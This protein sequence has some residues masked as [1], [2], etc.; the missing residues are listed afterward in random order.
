MLA[1]VLASIIP[2]AAEEREYIYG[3]ELMSPKERDAYRQGCNPR[4][5]RK[6]RA[7]TASVIAS[8]CRSAQQ[9]GVQLDERASF[10]AKGAGNDPDACRRTIDAAGTSRPCPHRDPGAWRK[11]HARCLDCH[12]TGPYA[13]DKRKVKSLSALRRK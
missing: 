11:L 5:A 9:R 7:S 3:A 13:P 1:A 12:G 4:R 2:A 6:A 10:A 8:G